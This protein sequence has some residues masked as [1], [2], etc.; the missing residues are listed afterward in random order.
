MAISRVQF[1]SLISTG[2]LSIQP[3]QAENFINN[4]YRLH[5]D[6]TV[7]LRK[8]MYG[9]VTG[10]VIDSRNPEQLTT[11]VIPETGFVL[12]PNVTYYMTTKEYV[13]C[14]RY[15]ACMAPDRGLAELGLT[16]IMNRNMFQVT[17]GTHLM[18]SLTAVDPILIY[19]EQELG[20]LYLEEDGSEFGH[21][22]IGGIITYCGSELDLPI[23]YCLCDGRY[24]SP[25]LTSRF[26]RGCGWGEIGMTGGSDMRTLTVSNLPAHHHSVIAKD[27]LEKE[28]FLAASTP[29]TPPEGAV[30][31]DA[32]VNVTQSS[33]DTEDTG[34]GQPFD[35]RPAYYQLAYI[36]RYQ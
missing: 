3:Y 4:Y 16:I 31:T 21:V 30:E 27:T 15:S 25:N 5:N 17:D 10:T 18:V 1:A 11:I 13:R 24:G 12:E 33:I 28:K 34:N 36:M 8:P 32:V 23:G 19:P 2:N 35:N 14:N 20:E 6:G 22:P 26:I 7:H 9:D 29:G